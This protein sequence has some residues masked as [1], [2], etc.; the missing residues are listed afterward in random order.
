[1]PRLAVQL[2]ALGPWRRHIWLWIAAA[3]VVVAAV[4]ATSPGLWRQQNRIP[5]QMAAPTPSVA[6]AAT[7]Q[8]V[9]SAPPA[10]QAAGTAP[11]A[12]TSAPQPDAATPPPPAPA[13]GRPLNPQQVVQLQTQLRALGFNPGPIDGMVGPRTMTAAKEFQAFYGLPATGAI[14]SNLLDAVSAKA[15]R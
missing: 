8:P 11:A 4:A 10:P 14:D 6:P 9:S 1:V 5:V 15:S 12:A 13:P 3:S 2:R 7:P